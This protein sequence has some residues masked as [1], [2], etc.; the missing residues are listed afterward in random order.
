MENSPGKETLRRHRT[1]L[2]QDTNITQ[3]KQILDAIYSKKIISQEEHDLVKSCPLSQDCAR[4]LLDIINSKGEG[5]CCRFL[6]RLKK[7]NK[8]LWR[9]V[10]GRTASRRQCRKRKAESDVQ[11]SPDTDRNALEVSQPC[12]DDGGTW[13]CEVLEDTQET[14]KLRLSRHAQCLSSED[15]SSHQTQESPGMDSDSST[16]CLSSS[17]EHNHSNKT[18]KFESSHGTEDTVPMKRLPP[19]E[20]PSCSYAEGGRIHEPKLEMYQPPLTPVETPPLQDTAFCDS[21][22]DSCACH[23]Q[24]QL[25][26]TPEDAWAWLH[27][28]DDIFQKNPTAA[29]DIRKAW[30]SNELAKHII[31]DRFFHPYLCRYWQK[32]AMFPSYFSDFMDFLVSSS[33]TDFCVKN[34]VSL[35]EVSFKSKCLSLGEIA[36]VHQTA[37]GSRCQL[38]AEEDLPAFSFGWLQKCNNSPTVRSPGHDQ[39]CMYVHDSIRQY[40]MACWVAH[41]IGN[42]SLHFKMSEGLSSFYEVASSFPVTCYSLASFLGKVEEPKQKADSMRAF[43][44]ALLQAWVEPSAS[45]SQ[46]S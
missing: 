33:A 20:A 4:H 35:P 12:C 42:P 32:H 43:L 28:V 8:Q 41:V 36:F 37:Y 21:H 18:R 11:A 44:E 13:K 34:G 14:I 17:T 9:R 24:E 45:C 23:V 22:Q 29:M 6:K 30:S 27:C 10:T 15:S 19:D 40:L 2:V 3:L 31:R 5:T 46:P 26:P 1:M 39:L 7:V 38:A 16:S 25:Y